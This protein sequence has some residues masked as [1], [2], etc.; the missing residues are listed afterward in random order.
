MPSTLI[1][2]PSAL[3]LLIALALLS[4]A[5]A[6]P[7][8]ARQRAKREAEKP[9]VFCDQTRALLLVG[10]QLSEA[11]SFENPVKRIA[12]MIGAGNL[13]WDGRVSGLSVQL[14]D[15]RFVVLK[16]VARR[17]AAWARKLAER[18]AEE[19]RAEADK[20]AGAKGGARRQTS[21]KL[22]TLA[23]TLLP[24]D[25]PSAL[26]V[27]R[28]SLQ[29]QP[30]FFLPHF[31]YKLAEVD[32]NA[33]DAFYSEALQIYAGRN[34]ES[35]LYLSAYPFALRRTIGPVS[36]WN[37]YA[38][39]EGFAG[40]P[41]LQRRYVEALLRLADARLRAL[42]EQPASDG[43]P[44]LHSEGEQ[45]LT[46]LLT[47]EALD[48]AR[49][50]ALLERVVSLRG[51]AAALLAADA[52]RRAST[53]S[54]QTLS[55]VSGSERGDSFDE[56]FER[57]ERVPD[58]DRRDAMRARAIMSAQPSVSLEK[59]ES[60]MLKISDAET[61]R[62]LSNWLYFSRA[63]QAS[64]D[65]LPDEAT[66][67]AE[68][69][70]ALDERALLLLGIAEE[71]LKKMNDKQRADELLG[72]VIRAARKAPETEAK[73]RALLGAAHLYTNF[74][75]MRGAEVLDEAIK[76]VNQLPEP[77]FS[78]AVLHR[79]LQGKNFSTFRAHTVPGFN[80]ENAFRELGPHDFEGALAVAR[81]LDDNHLRALAVNALSARCLEES[82][83]P[84]DNPGKNGPQPRKSSGGSKR[85][86]PSRQPETPK[87]RP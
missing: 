57:A 55:P 18:A 60:A 32:R 20:E 86:G 74:D 8:V 76:T 52:Q 2:K 49:D 40:R 29:E 70:E 71:G 25:V 65:G 54:Q 27:A 67:L 68:R 45:I 58:V 78:N 7:Q 41:E 42:A 73:A 79:A 61:R 23:L 5:A 15:Q 16:A 34:T 77:D 85:P 36:A 63:Q 50:A 35:L 19:T 82:P 28:L 12:V 75:Y 1:L 53:D 48:G 56:S 46:A 80:L 37:Y 62:Q 38:P 39:P 43:R 4:P 22:L 6:R 11:K 59:L 26:A 81:K 44:R 14:P 66:K 9:A 31:F 3:R 24:T 13:L 17:D 84:P 30:L 10:E 47:L 69:V 72:T 21:D 51:Q 33:A 87:Q 64:K 83:P